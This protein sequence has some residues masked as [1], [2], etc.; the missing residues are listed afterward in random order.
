MAAADCPSHLGGCFRL[1]SGSDTKLEHCRLLRL[2]LLS[3]C[4]E[5]V[6]PPRTLT[7]H[8]PFI[9]EELSGPRFRGTLHKAALLSFIASL[10]LKS[11]IFWVDFSFLRLLHSQNRCPCDLQEMN[12]FTGRVRLT[13]KKSRGQTK[14]TL[15]SF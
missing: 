12:D 14:V 5:A 1:L 10:P 11:L 13:T 4:T 6:M 9:P 2:I 7:W 8:S 15:Q 3:P